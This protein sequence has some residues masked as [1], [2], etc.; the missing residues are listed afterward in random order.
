MICFSLCCT[1]LRS[2]GHWQEKSSVGWK[3]NIIHK[4]FCT[5]SELNE[6]VG[7]NVLAQN[8][9]TPFSLHPCLFCSLLWHS[10]RAV[11]AVGE[12]LLLHLMGHGRQK[13]KKQLRIPPAPSQIVHL[14]LSSLCAADTRPSRRHKGRG[15]WRLIVFCIYM[16]KY[17]R[18]A[19]SGP[20]EIHGILKKGLRSS[21]QLL[22]FCLAEEQS[23]L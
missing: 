6:E 2:F 19:L 11:L 5:S 20:I 16:G 17:Q 14:I 22:L 13:C 8:E 15:E 12:I 3:R 21:T 18:H 4:G 1:A 7:A 9:I 23:S 10:D